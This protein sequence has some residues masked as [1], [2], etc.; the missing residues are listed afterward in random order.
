MAERTGSLHVRVG[1]MCASKT[2][3]I[4]KEITIHA[5]IFDDEKIAFINHEFDNRDVKNI[6]SSHSSTFKG[7]SDKITIF[8]A[9]QLKDVNVEDY[10]VIAVDEAQFHPDLYETVLQ[11]V[12]G[13]KH[14]YCAGLDG[15]FR[16]ESFGQ[17]S[18]LLPI[19][20]TFEKMHSVCKECLRENPNAPLKSIPAAFTKRTVKNDDQVAIGGTEMYV[21]VC[22]KHF[23]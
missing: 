6:I 12:G 23:F 22:R 13:G 5:D 16:M 18:K 19:A 8:R 11:W 4:I 9:K 3:T 21:P 10:F 20:D 14:V 2:W 1:P 17:I 15:D 7:I